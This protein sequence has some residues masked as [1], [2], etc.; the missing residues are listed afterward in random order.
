MDIKLLP[1]FSNLYIKNLPNEEPRAVF[2]E[3]HKAFSGY[4]HVY[5]IKLFINKD[6][7]I[8]ENANI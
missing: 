3:L 5:S 1:S 6:K 2:I 4:G 7:S 8:K